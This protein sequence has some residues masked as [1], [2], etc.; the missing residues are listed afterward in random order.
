[1]Q[2]RFQSPLEILTKDEDGSN[3]DDI[4]RSFRNIPSFEIKGE[5]GKTVLELTKSHLPKVEIRQWGKLISVVR[6]NDIR[7]TETCGWVPFVNGRLP[8]QPIDKCVT[9]KGDILA[10][11]FMRVRQPIE[12]SAA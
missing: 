9:K 11:M 7:Q 5:D 4:P 12:D 8:T 3:I 2:R 1:M 6:L 10:W